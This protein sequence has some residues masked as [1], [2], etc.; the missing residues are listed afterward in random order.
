MPSTSFIGASI[1]RRED[2]RLITGSSTYVDD[3]TLPGMLFMAIL[4]SPYP[5]ARLTEI[6][7]AAARALPGV[8]LV[9]TGED[10]GG[11]RLGGG[12][13]EAEGGEQS[14]DSEAA[15]S[16]P[17]LATGVARHAGEPV[18]A[19]V[20]ATRELAEDALAL[21]DV[22][23][24]PLPSVI[25][26]EAAM[27][28][29]APLVHAD[30]RGNLVRGETVTRGN[31]AEAFAAAEV[32]VSQRI[33][34]QRLAP[35]PMETRG[36]VAQYERGSGALT[37]WTS[38]QWAHGVRDE[39]ARLFKLP[40]GLV[41]VIAPEVGGGFGCKFGLY[42]ED[43][44]A[45]W[46]ARRAQRPVK[47]I[48]TRRESLVAT[49]HGRGQVAT[50]SL[51][52][53]RDGT[54]TG[55]RCSVIGDLGAYGLT[56][57]AGT[58]AR[59]ITGCYDIPNVESE[60]LDVYTHKTFLAAYRG[61]GRP[62]AAY[63]LER[64]VDLLARE[65]RMDPRELRR[66]NF[67]DPS[68]FPYTTP[69][70]T[71]FD[72]GDYAAALDAAQRTLDY[73]ALLAERDRLRAGRVV[74]VGL[75][76]YVEIYGFGWDVGDV[77]VA[78]GGS[79]TVYTG[80]S[81]HGQGQETTFAQIVADVLGVRPDDVTVVHGDTQMGVGYGT[82]G[83][84]GTAV[85]GAAVHK[86]AG[87]VRDKMRQIAAHLLEASPDDL[88][89]EDGTWS[90]RGVPGRQVSVARIAQAAHDP[91]KLPQ[92]MDPG[93]ATTTAFD[94]GATTAPFGAHIAFVEI[95]RDTGTIAVSRYVGVVKE[96]LPERAGRGFPW[97]SRGGMLMRRVAEC[98]GGGTDV[99]AGGE[100]L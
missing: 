81:P 47:W 79:V 71:T 65:L 45:L 100:R 97:A 25:D 73:P 72:T 69:G 50:I 57:L 76:S 37:L 85:G 68:A 11:L 51:A 6:D 31:V 41:R 53:R 54:I 83:S 82:G 1:R 95:D 38:T 10:L 66:K 35:N 88:E 18:A 20:A 86:A 70:R 12:G 61:A 89:L 30:R 99:G 14:A 64:A 92:G 4:R 34:S 27:R 78:P 93:L 43:A 52:A 77:R 28:P 48:E 29:D 3:I 58:T 98:A 84:R 33:V 8:A 16:R 80:V 44:L 19:V 67:I 42:P 17:L 40:E 15:P 63:Y 87:Q 55:L 94:P 22:R 24:D 49:N 91:G 9:V 13:G 21:I 74:G 26:L 5:H 39:L 62:E 36:V 23:Y 32:V 2:P 7:A 56:F 75:A 90:V 60:H 59:M 96:L 46:L